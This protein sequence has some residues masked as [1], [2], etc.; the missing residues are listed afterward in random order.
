[1]SG[2]LSFGLVYDERCLRHD[3]GTVHV[4]FPSGAIFDEVEHYSSS[5][6]T[7]RIHSLL[8]ASGLAE[9]F[10]PISAREATID[11]LAA[12]HTRDYIASIER[13][14]A[15]GSGDA[16]E[17][18]PVSCGSYLAAT[19]SAG[20]TMAAV[21]AVLGR[22]VSG[23]YVLARPPGHHALAGMGMGFCIFNN[24]ALGALH[25][26]RQG[27][28]RVM[29]VDWDVHHGNGSQAAFY[30]DP[31][32]LFLSLHQ[33]DWYPQGMGGLHQRGVEAGTGATINVP[34]PAGT[35]DKGYIEAFERIVV[36]AA[37]HFHPDL[38][39]V[40]AGQDAS[41]FDPLGRML[42]SMAGFAAIGGLVRDVANQVCEGRVVLVQEGGYSADYTPYCTVGAICGVTGT[43]LN[44]PDPHESASELVRAQSVYMN[45]TVEA[46]QNAVDAHQRQ[47][48]P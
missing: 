16:G 7:K 15:D 43:L 47:L 18:A 10:V 26:R 44:V 48:E 21:D 37:R 30:D 34:L 2:D 45:D 31:S 13:L 4:T 6:I 29:I 19:L 36:P 41:M 40:S 3:T 20:G 42:L 9:S 8:V 38:M 46:I 27:A 25:A 12:L 28:D 24:V 22:A 23:A 17:S 14:S 35:G 33:D 11:E 39:L 1:L 5:R 32:V